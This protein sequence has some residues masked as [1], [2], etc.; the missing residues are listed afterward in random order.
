SI[1]HAQGTIRRA[2]ATHTQRLSLDEIEKR[3]TEKIDGVQLYRAMA[4]RGLDYGSAFQGVA[5][6]VRHDGE[7]LADLQLPLEL[8]SEFRRYGIHPALLDAGLQVASAAIHETAVE[9]NDTVLPV[10]IR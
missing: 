9:E 6:I 1:L 8:S 10:G 2:G 7:A 5:R 4:D 3:C